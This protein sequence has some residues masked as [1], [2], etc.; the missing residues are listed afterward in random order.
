VQGFGIGRSKV[1]MPLAVSGQQ[2]NT[3]GLPHRS[4]EPVTQNV[5]A[6]RRPDQ[7]L[8]INNMPPDSTERHNI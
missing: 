6:S 7:A 2:K 8:M 3:G 5:A 1:A 4:V